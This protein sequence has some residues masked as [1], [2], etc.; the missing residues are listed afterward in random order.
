MTSEPTGTARPRN[1]SGG[2]VQGIRSAATAPPAHSTRL[3]TPS[4]TAV[5][6]GNGRGA[7]PAPIPIGLPRLLEH[8]LMIAGGDESWWHIEVI[9]VDADGE[10][11]LLRIHL[12][13]GDTI[14]WEIG[15]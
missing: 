4:G 12:I 3:A 2:V 1:P 11:D 7:V 9:D 6:S 10:I 14:V 13:N 5:G 15:R 8:L